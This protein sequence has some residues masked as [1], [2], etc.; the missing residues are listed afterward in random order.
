MCDLRATNVLHFMTKTK[1]RSLR[2]FLLRC[3]SLQGLLQYNGS[4]VPPEE[5][6]CIHLQH[7]AAGDPPTPVTIPQGATVTIGCSTW[8]VFSISPCCT[9][10]LSSLCSSFVIP[11]CAVCLIVIIVRVVASLSSSLC[12]D[13]SLQCD[14]RECEGKRAEE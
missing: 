14:M 1:I 5:C 10:V 3:F 6:G 11:S 7:Q 13:G 8:S 4:C 2:C 9:T 12:H